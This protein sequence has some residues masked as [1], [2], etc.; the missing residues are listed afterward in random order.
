MR[1]RREQPKSG[2]QDRD[3]VVALARGLEV[4]RAFG[5]EGEALGNGDFAQRTGLSKSTVSR[6]TYTLHKLGYLNYTPSTA[7]YQLAPS[8]LSLGFSCLAG[9]PLRQLAKPY[10]QEMADRT[11][12]PVA[13]ASRDRL[14]MVYLERCRGANPVTIA[15]D[16]GEHIKL[17]TSSTGRAHI[18]A[19]NDREREELFEELSAH[20]GAKWP[21]IRARIDESLQF[22]AEQGYCMSMGEWKPGVNAVAVPIR[23]RN[24]TPIFVFNCGGPDQYVCRKRLTEEIAPQLKGLVR[25]VAAVAS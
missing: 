2:A 14:A 10:M 25:R 6:L 22:Y 13:M 4:L 16:I 24:E 15:I 9:M 5:R 3:F 17:S 11:G 20:E 18:A 23:P 12:L 8:V 1:P 21:S 7:R 19:L